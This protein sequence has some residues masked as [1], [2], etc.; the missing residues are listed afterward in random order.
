[1]TNSFWYE[2]QVVPGYD[3]MP[4][5]D[6]D[7]L[8]AYFLIPL[9]GKRVPL[10]S[11]TTR[12]MSG[13]ERTDGWRDVELTTE[14]CTYA[15]LDAYVTAIFG[16]W[17]TENADVTLR[18]RQRDNTFEYFN[19]KAHL[20]VDGQDYEHITTLSVQNVRLRFTVLGVASV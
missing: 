11:T 17:Q 7:N 6:D 9:R 8:E 4:D 15:E 18:T 13:N 10:G 14:A 5:A 3:T 16:D 12:L 2:Y 20:P 19:A 1:M